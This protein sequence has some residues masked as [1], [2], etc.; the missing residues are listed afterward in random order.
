LVT[1]HIAI[2]GLGTASETLMMEAKDRA[3]AA[4][5]VLNLHQSYSPADT[6][7]DR[8]RFGGKDPLVHLAEV[9]F[10]DGN[11]T[12]GHANHLTDAECDAIVEHG[13]S[14]AW[15]P[16]ASMMW[17]H[18]GSIHGRHAELWRRGANIALGSD[19]ANWSNDFDLWRQANLAVLSARDS[20]GDRTYLVAED[21]LQM[22]TRAGARAAGMADRI[23][24]IEVGKRADIVIHTLNRP[25]M[26][27][28]TNMI[29]NLFYSSRSKSVHTVI[30]DGKVVMDEGKLMGIDEVEALA[31]INKA[32]MAMLARMG[33]TIEPNQVARSG[34]QV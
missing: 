7:A 32:A 24:S 2:L 31:E 25:E 18:G 4:G 9:G 27:P 22:A 1:G 14:L 5:V 20:H 11:V 13:P 15:A 3:D 10:L 6:D 34:R 21:G 17:G 23:G 29:R 26:I 30:V 33:K 12:F 19:S 16:A 28:T 8:Q